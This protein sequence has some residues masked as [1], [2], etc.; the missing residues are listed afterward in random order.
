MNHSDFQ[1]GTEFRCGDKL[2]RCTDVGTRTII[3]IQIGPHIEIA[4]TGSNRLRRSQI[5]AEAEGWFNG[6]PYAVAEHVFDENDISGC[7]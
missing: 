3:A 4:D 7:S 1:I 6:P 5:E 2:W